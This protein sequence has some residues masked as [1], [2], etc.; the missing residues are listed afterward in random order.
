[1]GNKTNQSTFII[2]L[3]KTVNSS[4][5]IDETDSSGYASK[6]FRGSKPISSSIKSTI[7]TPV[8][9]GNTY[10]YFSR[11]LNKN[12]L[13]G[14]YKQLGILNEDYNLEMISKTLSLMF[15]DYC[16]LDESCIKDVNEYYQDAISN[17][18]PS[19]K[20]IESEDYDFLIKQ[21]N[22]CP[23][24]E[25]NNKSLI[26]K[27]DDSHKKN[28]D[29]TYIFPSLFSSTSLEKEFNDTFKKPKDINSRSNIIALCH[30][31]CLEYKTKPSVESCKILINKQKEYELKHKTQKESQDDDLQR[32]LKKVLQQIIDSDISLL[33]DTD[34]SLLPKRIDTKINKDYSLNNNVK[35]N[36]TKYYHMIDSFLES[37][38]AKYPD[39]ST[40]LA[41]KI[42]SISDHLMTVHSSATMVFNE[43]V[44]V[45]QDYLPDEFKM[46]S[47]VNIIVSYFVQHCEVLTNETS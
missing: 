44:R 30:V 6:L 25:V 18:N 35:L 32:R 28:F 39:G 36:V 4:F 29:T 34:L 8:E 33:E 21:H 31:H 40:E 43:L 45:L 5:F 42:K 15:K 11:N 47:C 3:F 38:E 19:L 1:M 7:V 2:K 23:L 24:C 16:E 27:I 46:D 14:L 12:L 20:S 41:K 37:H 17:F 9:T 26:L 13:D 10:N 22:E